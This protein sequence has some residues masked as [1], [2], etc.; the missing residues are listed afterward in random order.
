MTSDFSAGG[1]HRS[2]TNAADQVLA[3]LRAKILS[4]DLTKGSR[5]PSERELSVYYDVSGPTIREAI[6][7]LSAMSLVEVRHGSGTYVVAESAALMHSAMTAVVELESIDLVSIL[8]LSETLYQQ[9][10]SLAVEQ[11]TD[12]ELADL[13]EKMVAVQRSTDG[14]ALPDPLREFLLALVALSHNR[15]LEAMCGYLIETQISIVRTS[16]AREPQLARRVGGGLQRQREAIVEAL[17]ARDRAA[18]IAAVDDYM[19]RGRDLVRANKLVRED[20]LTA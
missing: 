5:L 12:A 19:S 11:A 16:T 18:A 4:G 1:F 8:D 10:V 7:A 6:R 15:L 9:V 2:R 20:L 3:D 14:P 17:E 13:R